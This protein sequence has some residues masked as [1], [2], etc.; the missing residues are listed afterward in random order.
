MEKKYIVLIVLALSISTLAIVDYS[1]GA[2]EMLIFNQIDYAYAHDV[3]L[4]PL[5]ND[6]GSIAGYW[7]IWGKGHNFDFKVVLPGAELFDLHEINGTQICYDKNGLWG[8]GSL[9]YV[10]VTYGTLS[11]LLSKDLKKAMFCTEFSGIYNMTC[12]AWT[13]GG[14]FA[15]N[16]KT[17]NGTFFIIGKA[18]DFQGNFTLSQEGDRIKIVS[19]YILYAHGQPNSTNKIKVVDNVDYI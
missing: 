19:T 14:N 2:V 6:T 16:G 12:A 18:T 1:T 3:W 13:G 4:T 11:A 8:N 9:T 5:S 17:F 7:K 10:K 15:N